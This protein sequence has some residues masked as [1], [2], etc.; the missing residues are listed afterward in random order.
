M[1]LPPMEMTEAMDQI[2]LYSDDGDC[3]RI[4]LTGTKLHSYI[5]LGFFMWLLALCCNAWCADSHNKVKSTC[6]I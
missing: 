3:E 1:T 5:K 6:C 4:I 2:C